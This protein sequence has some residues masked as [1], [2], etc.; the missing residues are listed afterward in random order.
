MVSASGTSGMRNWFGSI[1]SVNNLAN[2]LAP[3]ML[4]SHR[5]GMAAR[6][7]GVLHSNL[8]NSPVSYFIRTAAC[9]KNP[10]LCSGWRGEAT[11]EGELGYGEE[12]RKKHKI[13][14]NGGKDGKHHADNRSDSNP[15]NH[16][17]RSCRSNSDGNCQ[18][19]WQYALHE[20]SCRLLRSTWAK[21]D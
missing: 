6:R 14:I 19:D 15:L 2:P 21:W 10:Q 18:T 13:E 12:P 5:A 17:N 9:S 8:A 4:P 11:G 3:N 16:N 7:A 1:L 20:S